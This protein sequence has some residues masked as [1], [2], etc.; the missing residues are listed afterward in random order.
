MFVSNY[1][2][3]VSEP[4][5]KECGH[6]QVVLEQYLDFVVNRTF[7]QTLLVHAGRAGDIRYNLDGSRYRTLHFAAHLPC[8]EGETRPDESKQEYGQTG[9]S[10]FALLP[11]AKL[12]MDALTEAW[13][14]TLGHAELLAQVR[15]RMKKAR[16][17]VPKALETQVNQ[18]LEYLITRG[19]AL[20]RLD[21]VR[22][23]AVGER[24][25]IDPLLRRAAE[26]ARN[27][28]DAGIFNAWHENVALPVVERWLLPEL[29]GSRDRAALI[30]SLQA[31]VAAGHVAFQRDGKPITDAAGIAASAEEHVDA[32]LARIL[33]S[34]LLKA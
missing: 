23:D 17:A 9:Q 31:H 20:Y 4:L 7:R 32:M 12:A 27:D 6:S 2:Q 28:A 21:P 24:I 13:P 18:L 3:Q 34:K 16:V 26:L 15:K 14:E 22:L 25:A 8:M 10:L 5:L 29:D 1:G 30:E 19:L 33:Q 11:S